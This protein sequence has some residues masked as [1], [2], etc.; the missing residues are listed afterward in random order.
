MINRDK[1][2]SVKN[3]SASRVIYRIPEDNIRREFAP[4]ETK[5][6][7]FNELEQLC[8]QPG[9]KQLVIEYLQILDDEVLSNVGINAQPEYYMSEQQIIELLTTGS[10]EAFLDCL[11]FAPTG[12]IDLIK[13]YA[14][15]LPLGDYQKKEAIRLKTGFSVDDAL[16][17]SR[18]IEEDTKALE[19]EA[20]AKK[21]NPADETEKVAAPAP[22]LPTGRRTQSNYK[23][24]NIK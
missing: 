13:K 16:K 23:I 24:V 8:F 1:L 22:V 14:V 15:S 20:F 21:E 7:S 2:Y 4:G 6:I 17:A 9:G 18:Q 5:R 12:I 3:R 19:R 11:D 10:Y